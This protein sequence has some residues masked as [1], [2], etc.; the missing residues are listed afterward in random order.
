MPIGIYCFVVGVKRTRSS[1]NRLIVVVVV[2]I[3]SQLENH[4]KSDI[5]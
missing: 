4:C 3:I 1:S 5:T 2:V